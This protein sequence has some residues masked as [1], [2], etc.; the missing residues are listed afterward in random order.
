MKVKVAAP[1]LAAATATANDLIL[2]AAR[3]AVAAHNAKEDRTI[4]WKHAIEG[5][6]ERGIQEI[7]RKG[8][9]PLATMFNDALTA[10][11]VAEGTASNYLME[12]RKAFNT[13]SE[14]VLN[15]ARARQ[16]MPLHKI[17]AKLM[18]HA[19]YPAW[20]EYVQKSY[21]DDRGSLDSIFEAYLKSEGF[22]LKA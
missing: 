1:T 22:T 2:T 12:F 14:P 5:L 15:A 10:S 19:G 8:K 16:V 18:N 3:A 17:V 6:K 21:N 7:G 13:G 20:I 9:C 11:G 4:A